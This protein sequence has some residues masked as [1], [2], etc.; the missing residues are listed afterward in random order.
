MASMLIH[1]HVK[2]FAAWKKVFDSKADLRAAGG[3]L[4]AQLY[5]SESDPNEITAIFQW[6][7]LANAHSFAESPEL[8]A[9]MEAS[10]VDGKPSMYF[11]NEA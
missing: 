2:D 8:K 6:D 9:A 11:L 4:S 10:G 7:S 3:E 5:R 1:H